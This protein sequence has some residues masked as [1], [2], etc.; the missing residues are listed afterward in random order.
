MQGSN[1]PKEG[2]SVHVTSQAAASELVSSRLHPTHP[3]NRRKVTHTMLSG[4][5]KRLLGRIKAN[6]P[7]FS[8]CFRRDLVSFLLGSDGC[9]IAS[10]SI[11]GDIDCPLDRAMELV[12]IARTVQSFRSTRWQCVAVGRQT[13]SDGA[14]RPPSWQFGCPKDPNPERRT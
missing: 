13:K 10:S 5:S 6:V 2:I 11:T 9:D 8:K 14:C 1:R 12:G 3:G 4:G 7:S